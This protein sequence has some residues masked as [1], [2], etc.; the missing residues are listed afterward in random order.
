VWNISSLK[1]EAVGFSETR[2]PMYYIRLHGAKSIEDHMLLRS[3]TR[4]P[5]FP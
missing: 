4:T 5:H 2:V 1:M 3:A